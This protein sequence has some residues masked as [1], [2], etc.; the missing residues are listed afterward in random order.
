M[1]DGAVV[2]AVCAGFQIVG[3]TFPGADGDPH[4]GVGL[5]DVDTAKG[6]GP[7]A[8]GEVLVESDR[9]GGRCRR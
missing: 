1:A 6:T 8:V 5:L 7:R 2:L 3:R 9:C 4:E